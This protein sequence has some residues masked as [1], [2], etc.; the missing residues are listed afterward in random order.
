MVGKYSAIND[1]KLSHA[2]NDEYYCGAV[3]KMV[4]DSLEKCIKSAEGL[5]DRKD[6]AIQTLMEGLVLTG[7]AMSFAGN[8][9][10]ASGS[11][12]HLSHFIEMMY[13]FDGKE[14]PLHGEKVGVNTLL[15]NSIREKISNMNPDLDKITQT[16]HSFDK[17]KWTEDVRILFRQAAP[18]VIRINEKEKINDLDERLARV[19]RIIGQWDKIVEILRDVPPLKEIEAVLKKAEAPVTLKELGVDRE[20]VINGLIY[21]KEVRARYTVLQLAW[22]LGV[23]NLF[24]EEIGE[25]YC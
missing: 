23:L 22:D 4:E 21:A 6:G 11:E 10:P 24:A 3:A 7:I 13:L 20:T 2:I 9:R 17:G 5:K 15:M 14:A 18:G 25:V 16:A 19:A 8:S 12:H 1:W